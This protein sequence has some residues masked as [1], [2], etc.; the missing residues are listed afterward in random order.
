MNSEIKNL[1][2]HFLESV[3]A[4]LAE[5]RK[6]I[7]TAVNLSMVYTYFEIGK[8]IVEEEQK[9]SDR[10]KYG[11]YVIDKLSNHLTKEFGKGF[12]S[13]NFK[14]I[15]RF[16]LVYSKNEIGQT[17]FAEFENYPTTPQDIGFI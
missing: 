6:K 3:S 2:N 13:S 7:K 4:L 1:D 15:R 16:Y 12:S 17:L 9:G 10:A 14:M 8:M 5:S 11:N